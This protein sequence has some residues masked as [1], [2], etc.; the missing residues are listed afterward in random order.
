L[1]FMTGTIVAG[2]PCGWS[3]PRAWRCWLLSRLSSRCCGLSNM[4]VPSIGRCR[5]SADHSDVSAQAVVRADRRSI[6]TPRGTALR[7]VAYFA[8]STR[9]SDWRP[10]CIRRK[11][12][13]HPA[14]RQAA[15]QRF[16]DTLAKKQGFEGRCRRRP[17]SQDPGQRGALACPILLSDSG[18]GWFRARCQA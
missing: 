17:T 3:R 13:K 12:G 14:C 11:A 6:R 5:T 18:G 7:A 10:V 9:R 4:G 16:R 15:V 8:A 2:R 1:I